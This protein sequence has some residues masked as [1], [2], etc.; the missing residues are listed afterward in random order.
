VIAS[1]SEKFPFRSIN[2]QSKFV[3]C[4][5]SFLI[6]LTTVELSCSEVDAFE[7]ATLVQRFCSASCDCGIKIHKFGIF[8]CRLFR[9]QK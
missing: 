3:I 1:F 6:I 8:E 7:F 2:P 4:G 9:G 5:N